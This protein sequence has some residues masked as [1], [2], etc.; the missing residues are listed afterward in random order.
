M[1]RVQGI[2]PH[3]GRGISLVKLLTACYDGAG[4]G[5]IAVSSPKL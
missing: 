2:L 4:F 5:P 3:N 1:D